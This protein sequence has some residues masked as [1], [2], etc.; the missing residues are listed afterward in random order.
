[1]TEIVAFTSFAAEA[2][3]A[4]DRARRN[5]KLTEEADR[6]SKSLRRFTYAAWPHLGYRPLPP[7]LMHVDA[8]TD[9]V[10]AAYERD[11]LSLLVTIQ[12]GAFKSTIL[13]VIAP[14]WRWTHAPGE[15]FITG[16]HHDRLATRDT[17]ASRRL[18]MTTW[19]Q[20]RWGHM[21]EWLPGEN[22]KTEYNNDR[23]GKR[24]ISHV[25]GGT[26]DRGT[27]QQID[28]PHNATEANYPDTQLEAVWEWWSNTWVSRLDDTNELPG[29]SI[30]VGQRIHEKDLIGRLIASGDW[31]HLC[32]PTR[33]ASKHPFVTPP[34]RKTA[35]RREPLTG[36]TRTVEGELLMPKLQN[37]KQLARKVAEDG[38]TTR[39]FLTQY[40]QTPVARAG[41]MLKRAGW[42]YYDREMSFYA[43]REAFTPERVLAL[44]VGGVL[45]SFSSIVCSWDTSVKD[46][47]HSD[48]VAGGAWA[49]RADRP[50]DR[51]LLRLWHERAGLNETIEAM[52]D[53][54]RWAETHWPWCP[55]FSLIEKSANGPDAIR[56]I[57][58]KIQGVVVWP[59]VGESLGSKEMR[60]EAA[61]PAL[62]GGNCYLPGESNET[63][64][65]YDGAG[66]PLDVQE[67]V[68]ELA[69]FNKGSHDDLVDHWSQMVNYT[70]AR[71]GTTDVA[72]PDDTEQRVDMGEPQRQGHSTDMFGSIDRT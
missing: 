22:L 7:N 27:I 25:G 17:T 64:T 46:R 12:P 3:A 24:V 57:R 9:H 58:A 65:D 8:I 59:E 39:I 35:G 20:A 30:V 69:E 53:L 47:E 11:I 49:V 14:A 16:S 55:V 72:A 2:N 54:H 34:K 61:S 62:D 26:G 43:A 52:L 37:E 50:A 63:M 28:D 48:F 13:S 70:R 60:A 45:P 38:V 44:S 21:F 29:V 31:T 4:L 10:Q 33:Y 68:E 56:A 71:S 18:M 6:L 67:F 19:F 41:T 42:R 51:W 23:G 66:T 15:R 32:L 5:E 1:M 40:Q 36:D